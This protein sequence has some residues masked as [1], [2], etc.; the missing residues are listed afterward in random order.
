MIM[1]NQKILH[2]PEGVRDIYN[3]EC[4]R[5]K[6]LEGRLHQVLTS[7]GYH[8]IET[9]TFEYFDVFGREVGTMPSQDLYKFFDRE[10]STLVLRPDF[11]PSI[12]RCVSRYYADADRPVRLCYQGSTFVNYRSLQG[13]LK[14]NTQMGAELIGEASADGDAEIIA[15][16]TEAMR[17]SG[18]AEFQISVGH[19]GFFE[20]LVREA[21]FDEDTAER[22]K[23][24]IHNHNTFGTEKFLSQM[25][26]DSRIAGILV[27]LPSLNGGEDVLR[28]AYDLSEGLKAQHAV[29]RLLEVYGLLKAYGMERYVSFDFGML[30]AYRYYT[31]IVFRGYTYGTGN[32][33]VRGGRYDSLLEHF[34]AGR[35]AVGF[36][37]VI[38]QL[39]NALQRQKIEILPEHERYAILYTE[40]GRQQAHLR[41]VQYRSQG[42]VTE[43]VRIPA[44]KS[45]DD[46]EKELKEEGCYAGVIRI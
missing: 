14:E 12:A 20:A 25:E 33:V 1:M 36:V 16:A 45:A 37:I 31:G 28:K 8:D 6:V 18:L 40:D 23:E 21:G 34:G 38:G 26:I 19:I 4:E 39:M 41:A 44:G 15:M 27:Q 9:P 13:R 29:S 46:M 5:K 43:L 17:T 24:L 3:G 30:P 22:L 35:P 7:Y 10:G 2:T 11:T 32:A 42:K